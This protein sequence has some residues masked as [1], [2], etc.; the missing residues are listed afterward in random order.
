[1]PIREHGLGRQ[2]LRLG[3]RMPMTLEGLLDNLAVGAGV[4]LSIAAINK[5][6]KGQSGI[7][8]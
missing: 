8:V 4:F 5:C 1:M 3:L 2:G 7:P 6:M